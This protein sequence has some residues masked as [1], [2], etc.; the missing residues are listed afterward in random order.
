MSFSHRKKDAISPDSSILDAS[1]LSRDY[2]KEDVVSPHFFILDALLL[3]PKYDMENVLYDE[4]PSNSEWISYEDPDQGYVRVEFSAPM[5]P[6]KPEVE[7]PISNDSLI[8]EYCRFTQIV[9]SMPH[10]EGFE[11]DFDVGVK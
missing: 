7:T 1:P 11:A 6:S 3:S 9:H 4:D 10:L 8:T 5:P 2:D